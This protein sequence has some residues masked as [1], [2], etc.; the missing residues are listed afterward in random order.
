MLVRF[1][2][3]GRSSSCYVGPYEIFQRVDKVAYELKLPR[4]LASVDL[5]FH[6][7]MLNKCIVDHE[8][9]FPI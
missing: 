4:Q 1:G 9:I 3:K 5:V 8:S 2:K 7:P 6:V